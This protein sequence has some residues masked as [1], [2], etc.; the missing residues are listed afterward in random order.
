MILTKILTRDRVLM[1]RDHG[2][3]PGFFDKYR[4]VERALPE[5]RFLVEKSSCGADY[6]P[7]S[8][9]NFLDYHLI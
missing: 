4:L 3:K 2:Q 6:L 7:R 5:T 8:R 9:L 1:G